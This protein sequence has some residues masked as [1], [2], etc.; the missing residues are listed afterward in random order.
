MTRTRNATAAQNAKARRPARGGFALRL[1]LLVCGLLLLAAIG[2]WRY[3]GPGLY[4]AS[5]KPEAQARGDRIRLGLD[6]L[7]AIHDG[8]RPKIQALLEQGAE[9]NIADESGHSALMQAALYADVDLMRQLLDRGADPNARARDGASPLIRS[10]HAAEKFQL[11]LGR[12]AYVDNMAM[13]VAARV[14]G[15]GRILESLLAHGGNARAEIQGYTALMAAAGNGDEEAV[16]GLLQHGAAARAQM[17][18]G[19]TALQGAAIDG[20]TRVVAMLLD[21]GADPNVVCKIGLTGANIETPVTGAAVMGHVDTLDQLIAHGGNVNIQGGQFEPTPLLLA[22][23][24]GNVNTVRLLLAHGANANASDWEG[25]TPLDWAERS[26]AADISKLLRDAGATHSASPR[27]RSDHS[28]LTTHQSPFTTERIQQ[29]I[30]ASLPPLQKS[31]HRFSEKKD[32]VTCHQHSLLAMTTGLARR[33]G[34]A[35]DEA[36]ASQ[37]RAYVVRDSSRRIPKLLVGNG[38]DSTLAPYTLVGLAAEDEPA[39]PLTDALVHYLVLRQRPDGRWQTENNRPPEDGSDFLFTALSVRGLQAY[40]PRGRTEEIARRIGRARAWLESARPRDTTD[41]FFQLLGLRWS[42]ADADAISRSARSL[43]KQQGADGGWSQ[44]PTLPSDAYATGGALY[45]LHEGA[46]LSD[47]DPAY[48]HGVE[49]LLSTQLPDGSWYVP[50][51]CFPLVEYFN[52][53]FPHGKSQFISAA[54]TC[55]ATMA[56][57]IAEKP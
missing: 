2:L 43:L 13:I 24:S 25:R 49:F 19:Y 51:R 36:L 14:P 8:D 37:E 29:A 38:I 22:A 9:A 16:S 45:A 1:P 5:N 53:G 12:G 54:A 28:P 3:A 56:L 42:G 39:N 35:F 30:A 18:N 55:W 47:D 32:C 48:R 44:I 6:L 26:G 20:N 40:A 27:G 33:H 34:I 41:R 15:A 11:L 50:T 46:G 31:G 17:A 10:V 57:I 23:T 7:A 21:R 52:S 4:S